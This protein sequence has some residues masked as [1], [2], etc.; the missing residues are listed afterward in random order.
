MKDSKKQLTLFSK[1]LS[2]KY[3]KPHPEPSCLYHEF[4]NACCQD[5]S[6]IKS[7]STNDK[8]VRAAQDQWN[9]ISRDEARRFVDLQND[10]LEHQSSQISQ[11]PS[12][13]GDSHWF[14]KL[15]STS[16]VNFSLSNIPENKEPKLS[17]I[18]ENKESESI[19]NERKRKNPTSSTTNNEI[20]ENF[21]T[22]VK[23]TKFTA[24]I[25]YEKICCYLSSHYPKKEVFQDK[26][27]ARDMIEFLQKEEQTN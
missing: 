19:L 14:R 18:P 2:I 7:H 17:T 8:L 20:N 3:F 13:K 5:E 24:L 1:P 11:T 22:P 25:D 23:K 16:T 9:S 21:R 27:L 4:I 6:Y 10:K 26:I 15:S 12:S